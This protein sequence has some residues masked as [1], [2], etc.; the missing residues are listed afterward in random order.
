MVQ[1]K[2]KKD[3]GFELT[4]RQS[5]IQLGGGVVTLDE[6]KLSEPGEYEAGS[7]EVV[8]GTQAALIVWENIQI[9]YVF[10]ADKPTSF[11]K[12]QFTPCNVLVIDRSV[13]GLDKQK[14]TELLEIYD[15]N[16][17]AFD[18]EETIAEIKDALK[19]GQQDSLKLTESTLP[20]EGRDLYL[21]TT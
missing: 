21:L 4:N 6:Q 11:E 20:T 5:T 9:A 17:V 8:Y 18:A 2:A 1:L 15:P 16:I 19:I 13:S 14:V 3:G 12:S 10:N 7:I